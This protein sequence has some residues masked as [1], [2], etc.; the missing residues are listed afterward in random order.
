MAERIITPT[1]AGEAPGET[2]REM[3]RIK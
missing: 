1:G 3:A 2:I